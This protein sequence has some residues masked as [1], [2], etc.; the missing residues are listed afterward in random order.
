VT[1]VNWKVNTGRMVALA[2]IVLGG[3]NVVVFVLSG[4]S[5]LHMGVLGA[6]ALVVGA[7]LVTRRPR[8]LWLAFALAPLTLTIGV[9]ALYAS[10]GFGGFNPSPQGLLF[11]LGL[12]AYAT[13]AL[14]LLYYLIVK[15]RT[16]LA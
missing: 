11:N 14:L 3:I 13:T 15:R 7:G 4:A 12:L 6:L 5:M 9:S 2:H 16:L 10:L 1:D 8:V